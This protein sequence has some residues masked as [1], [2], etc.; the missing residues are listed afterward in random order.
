MPGARFRVNLKTAEWRDWI[1]QKTADQQRAYIYGLASPL[2]ARPFKSTNLEDLEANLASKVTYKYNE[3]TTFVSDCSCLRC[4]GGYSVISMFQVWFDGY[5]EGV[6]WGKKEQFWEWLKIH[7][8]LSIYTC[9]DTGSPVRCNSL[10]SVMQWLQHIASC[11]EGFCLQRPPWWSYCQPSLPTQT[12]HLGN[13]GPSLHGHWHKFTLVLE[14]PEREFQC[15]GCCRHW[16]CSLSGPN[17]PFH[18]DVTNRTPKPV[19]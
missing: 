5:R 1:V 3:E 15:G 9:K 4:M 19:V 8:C 18:L 12:C 10:C 16:N 14:S 7:V 17:L 13:I 11:E 6:F 2:P